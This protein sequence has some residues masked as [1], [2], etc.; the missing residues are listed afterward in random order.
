MGEVCPKCGGKI[1]MVEYAYPHPQR[2]DGISEH[3]CQNALRHG[4]EE[5]TC[6]YRVGRWCEKELKNGESENRYCEGQP[7]QVYK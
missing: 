2:Y 1:W 3:A 6:D 7:H 5:P 4:D